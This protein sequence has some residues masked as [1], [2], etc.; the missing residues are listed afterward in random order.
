M[1]N[2]KTYEQAAIEAVAERFSMTWEKSSDSSGGWLATGRKRVAVEIA[3]FKRRDAQG[4][5]TRLGLRFDKVVAGLTQRL[6]GALDEIVPERMT[7]VLTLTAPIRLPAKTADALE[8]KI[9]T[10]LR[11]KSPLR[12]AKETIYGNHVRIRILSDQSEPASK[13]I[14]FVHNPN[15]DPLLLMEITE[16]LIEIIGSKAVRRP[17][18]SAGGRWLVLVGSA[19]SSY[20]GAYRHLCSQIPMATEFKKIVVVLPD[21]QVEVLAE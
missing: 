16:E 21:G 3:T 11:R 10:L 6:R 14:G 13:M 9:R 8:D 1:S 2:L 17:M 5:S 18:I 4:K 7:V 19:G 20:L 15:W 12:D